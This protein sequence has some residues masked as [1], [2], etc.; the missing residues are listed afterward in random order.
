LGDKLSIRYAPTPGLA[1]HPTSI[2]RHDQSIGTNA[3]LFFA[4]RDGELNTSMVSRVIEAIEKHQPVPGEPAVASNQLGQIVGFYSVFGAVTPDPAIPLMTNVSGFDMDPI[5]SNL[6]AW[7][8]LPS[9][10]PH[11]IFLPGYRTAAG[12]A[13]L[14]DG[15]ELFMTLTALH[16]AGVRDVVISRWP[17][18]GESTAILAKEFLQ[19]L[20]FE[21]IDPS[22]RRAIQTLRRT[23]LVPES[24]PLLGAKD[25]KRDELT[26]D[27]PLFWSGYMLV[28]PYSAP[29]D[30]AQ[31][32]A[33][34]VAPPAAA[35]PAVAQPAA[36]PPAVAPPATVA[37]AVAVPPAGLAPNTVPPGDAG[38]EN[39]VPPAAAGT[40]GEMEN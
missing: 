21:G 5:S 22:W 40:D 15:R 28:S 3:Q 25:Q 16:V 32:A 13:Q 27:H 35:A 23:M 39:G 34:A 2:A 38:L 8:R 14:G 9:N 33:V 29:I 20:P 12:G 6:A 19:E 37:P 11:G 24:E 36:I 31:P 10:V 30:K 7:M 26:G 17:V 18:G 4:P 1:I